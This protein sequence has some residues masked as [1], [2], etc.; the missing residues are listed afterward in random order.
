MTS[1]KWSGGLQ[2]TEAL[3]QV[4]TAFNRILMDVVYNTFHAAV[5]RWV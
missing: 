5:W 3:E 2:P 1:E 4:S